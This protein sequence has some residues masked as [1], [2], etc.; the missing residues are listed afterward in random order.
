[1]KGDAV[2]IICHCSFMKLEVPQTNSPSEGQQDARAL[3]F[4]SLALQGAALLTGTSAAFGVFVV[5]ADRITPVEYWSACA[6]IPFAVFV[7][8]YTRTHA[9]TA[10]TTLGLPVS[11]V[12]W[13]YLITNTW[14]AALIA[15]EIPSVLVHLGWGIPLTL[16]FV[17][18]LKRPLALVMSIS[19]TFMQIAAVA[20]MIARLDITYPNE[21]LNVA[22]MWS[23]SQCVSL[24]LIFGVSRLM[25]AQVAERTAAEARLELIRKEAALE[26]Q[27]RDQR[28]RYRRLIESSLDVVAELTADGTLLEITRN[29]VELTG[30]TRE[31]LLGIPLN[32]IVEADSYVTASRALRQ[33]VA[34]MPSSTIEQVIIAKDGNRVPILASAVYSPQDNIVFVIVRDLRDRI[35]Q[36][37]RARHAS[38]LESLGQ[39]TGG[40]AHDF[41]NLLTV[42][43]GEVDRIE[44]IVEERAIDGIDLSR[45]KRATDGAFDLTTRLLA[46]SRK[47]DLHLTGTNLKS[48]VE[49][50]VSLLSPTIGGNFT[51]LCNARDVWAR[52]DA[53][54][55]QAAIIN[56]AVNARDA[57]PTGGEIRFSAVPVTLYE[58]KTLPWG[59]IDAGDYAVIAVR[60][61]GIGIAADVLP[62]IIEPYFTTKGL[63]KGTGL[64]L[65]MA[66]QLAEKL[67]GGLTVESTVGKGTTVALYVPR[68]ANKTEP[69]F[70]NDHSPL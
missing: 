43:F 68:S 20:T 8:I 36:E 58:A 55:L 59:I 33:V 41:N 46:F 31:E 53:P 16:L 54:E 15:D 26:A 56:L 5:G 7:F 35:A 21:L 67:G 40:I 25:E 63:G 64:G 47:Q 39:L 6:F 19:A 18:V 30:Y 32:E 1:M 60:D 27:I 61:Q 11:V 13:V 23:L 62:K 69:E 42:M 10:V 48:V 2:A 51:L 49:H 22:S 37:E 45:L 34:G 24:A 70:A 17:V 4:G 28:S 9:H 66:F 65:S 29:C 3:R 14:S 44:E 38:R 52:V 50:A 57:M 12:T